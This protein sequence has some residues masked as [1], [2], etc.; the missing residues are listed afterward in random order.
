MKIEIMV[1]IASF[2]CFALDLTF[3]MALASSCAKSMPHPD[4]PLEGGLY[5]G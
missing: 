4:N 1:F 2:V 5:V 3:V